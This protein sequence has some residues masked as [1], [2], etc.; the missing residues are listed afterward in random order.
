[1]AHTHSQDLEA[2]F[3]TLQ[4]GLLETQKEVKQLSA[5]V[6]S[7][8]TTINTTMQSSMEEVKQE[9][10]TQLESIFA[11]LCTKLK[12]PTDDPF[13]DASP[14]TEGEHSSH[15]HTFQPHHFQRDL[16]LPRVDVT[17]FDG[18]DPT[19]WVT[20][21]EHYFSLYGITDDLAKHRYGVLH[22][23]QERWQWWQ[24]RRA[25]RQGYIAWTQFVTELYECFDTNTNHL[26]RLTKLK[27]SGTVEDFIAAFERLAFRT[28][29]MTDAFFRE[30]F[31]SGLKDEIRAH[32]LMARPSS[33]VE[34]TK[35][36]K[37]ATQVVSSQNRKPSFIP[38][39]K[40]V[41]PTTPSAPLKIQKLTRDE[42][43]KRQLKG[44]CYNCDDK[45]FTGHKC[46]EQNIFM[47]ISKDISEEDVETPLVSES[48]EIT[49]ITP[50][51]DPPEVELIISLNALTGFSTPQTLKLI[52]Y[53]K[54]WK[55]IILVDSG[56]THNFI[57]HC[58]AQETHCYIHAVNNFQIMIA[59][60]GSMKCGGHCEN[61]CLQIGDYHLKSHMF[62]I[63]MGGCGIVLG[64]DWLRTLGPILMDFKAL[65]MQF[66]QEG[67]QYK[68]Q[69]IT[70]SSPEVISFHRMEKLLKK[71][72]SGVI[73]QLHAI[74]ATETPLVLQDLQALLS[75]HQMV[76]YT[77]QQLPPS[78]GVHDHSIPL[79]P[80]ILP[81]NIRPYRHPF[82][83]KNEIE[84][85]VQE[86]LNAGVIRP[87]MSPY[88]SLVVMVLKKEDLGECVLT[89]VPSTN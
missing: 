18:S 56:S 69:G 68:F 42:M 60:G 51:S 67:H 36:A 38:H 17:K 14:K 65:T 41:N 5:N 45:Y 30:C 80:G 25:S 23:D 73:A 12:I 15:S 48:P 31:I 37:E 70:A 76:F 82:S 53:I 11:S 44:L 3:N 55:V 2:C 35:R 10:T 43:A 89:F 29:G 61:V 62:S 19:S 47:A 21:M 87:S 57:H 54:H 9:L 33:W 79:V 71:G 13:S 26:G 32:V 6:A 78:H 34:A 83:Q 86:L 4:S 63:D 8:D 39:P 74:Q 58:I 16:H 24:W 84:K 7:I 1:M 81:P 77:P 75:K 20:Q 59:N 52:G 64:A 27:Q 66:D 50:P 72:H 40:P 85:M 49:D 88:S 46:K 22:L 28:E